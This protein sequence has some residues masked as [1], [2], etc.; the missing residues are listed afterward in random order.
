MLLRPCSTFPTTCVNLTPFSVMTSTPESP[1]QPLLLAATASVQRLLASDAPFTSALIEGFRKLQ[2]RGTLETGLDDRLVIHLVKLEDAI[3][4]IRVSLSVPSDFLDNQ[5]SEG[6]RIELLTYKPWGQPNDLICGGK[7]RFRAYP[8][9]TLIRL[10]DENKRLACASARC[11]ASQSI[12]AN[13]RGWQMDL[14]FDISPNEV[15]N[16]NRQQTST[17]RTSA[18]P[19]CGGSF[20]WLVF[21]LP[22][23]R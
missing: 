8:K 17:R 15:S 16:A 10:L 4:S 5:A 13:L 3:F 18:V 19:S 20:F 21:N 2:A 11:L 12:F 7:S 22:Y 14:F 6:A 23:E 1:A 9:P